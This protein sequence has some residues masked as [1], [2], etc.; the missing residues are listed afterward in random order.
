MQFFN[1]RSNNQGFTLIELLI[2]LLLVGTLS[3][4]SGPSF[5][6]LLNRGK[7]NN[8]VAQ[9]QG[10]L[11]E[12][13]R[14]ALRRSST[15]R[16]ALTSGNQPKLTSNCFDINDYIIQATVAAASGGTTVTVAN[17][18][19][20]ISNGTGIIFSNGATGVV[21]VNAPKAAT[22]LTLASNGLSK[23]IPIGATVAFRTI[24]DGVAMATNIIK[25]TSAGPG[26][27]IQI[28][29]G[30]R[31]NTSFITDPENADFGNIILY[32]SNG[33]TSRR[34]CV[35]ISNGIGILRSGTYT[36]IAPIT[37]LTPPAS[38][39]TTCEQSK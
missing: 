13:H 3:A 9:V 24:P 12:A 30:F 36:N 18:P 20:A 8:A 11:Q 37:S 32:Q 15:C 16:V 21:S 10:A 1:A 34:K 22:S 23:A 7:V 26:I 19:V 6:G 38:I 4:F 27:P 25:A 35:A 31:R 33:P 5:L 28:E 29:F 2:I 17:L 39:T 14:G